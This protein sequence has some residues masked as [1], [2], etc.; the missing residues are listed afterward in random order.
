M[1]TEQGIVKETT[2]QGAYV[3]IQRNSCCSSCS[4]HGACRTMSE[5]EMLVEAVNELQA[6]SGDHVEISVPSSSFLKATFL[7]YFAPILAFMFA[8]LVGWQYAPRFQL[9]PTLTS[10]GAG[11]GALVLSFVVVRAIDRRAGGK[12]RYLPRI[13]RILPTPPALPDDDNR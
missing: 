4:S 12:K 8:S 9:D 13:T 3:T 2:P 5:K 1:V 7:V 10:A 6:R 11:A